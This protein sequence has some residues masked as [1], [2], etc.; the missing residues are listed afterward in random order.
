MPFS[1][2]VLVRLAVIVEGSMSEFNLEIVSWEA[3]GFP[4]MLCEW[5]QG[6]WNPSLPQMSW[7]CLLMMSKLGSGYEGWAWPGST[8]VLFGGCWQE[9]SFV[10]R[11]EVILRDC[12]M[13]GRINYWVESLFCFLSLTF[14]IAAWRQLKHLSSVWP[15]IWHLISAHL[16]PNK[17]ARHLGSEKK[18]LWKKQQNPTKMST[19]TINLTE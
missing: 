17:F 16:V 6:P 15:F 7:V 19:F 2:V 8:G 18:F 1:S 10:G 13:H 4:V 11:R 9:K 3:G 12:S 14:A 5:V